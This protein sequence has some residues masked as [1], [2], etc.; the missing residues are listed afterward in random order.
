MAP[1]FLL[2]AGYVYFTRQSMGGAGGLGGL[3]GGGGG[4]GAGGRG[5]MNVGKAQVHSA[6]CK[7]CRDL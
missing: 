6:A 1:T 4:G 7:A 2:I 5:I 3:G